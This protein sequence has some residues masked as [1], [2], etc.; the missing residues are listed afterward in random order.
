MA[1]YGYTFIFKDI[2]SEV[3]NL[4][5]S[6]P[7]GG[8]VETSGSGDVELLTQKVFRN[9]KPYLLGVQQAPVLTFDVQFLSPDELLSEDVRLIQS[10][11]FGQQTYNKL[12]IVQPDMQDIYYNCFI[13][14]PR[15]VRVGNLIRGISG[16]VICDSPFAWEYPKTFSLDYPNGT[17]NVNISIDNIS[18][19]T[20]Y[21][22]PSVFIRMDDFGG[23]VRLTNNSDNGR[24]FEFTGL[25]AFEEI[26]VDNEKCI[27]TSNTGLRRL[28]NFNKNWF[29]LLNG[30][31][32]I[33]AFGNFEH[34]EITY[35]PARKV[36]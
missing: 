7:D 17:A 11:L 26:T 32:N 13:T 5:I 28:S 30:L 29:R 6:S 12:Q 22:F 18:D 3:Y 21:E 14:N 20:Y 15:I 16:T 9:P 35:S 25:Q 27:I 33:N 1:F 8:M 34:L 23:T 2:P 31:N 4:Y 10:W 19:N 24:V 36:A